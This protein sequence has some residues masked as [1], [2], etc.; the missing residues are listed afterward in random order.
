MTKFTKVKKYPH[1]ANVFHSDRLYYET[2]PHSTAPSGV[3]QDTC[4]WKT[5][6][7]VNTTPK[8]SRN[9]VEPSPQHDDH[10]NPLMGCDGAQVS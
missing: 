10:Y 2:G 5:R 9:P 8:N 6:K 7:Q 4:A 3:T 1:Y